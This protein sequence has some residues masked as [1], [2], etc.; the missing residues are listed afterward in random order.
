MKRNKDKKAK[1]VRMSS[2]DFK[3]ICDL[4]FEDS[5]RPKVSFTKFGKSYEHSVWK[6]DQ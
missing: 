6:T 3:A 5:R 1:Y 2:E 4:L